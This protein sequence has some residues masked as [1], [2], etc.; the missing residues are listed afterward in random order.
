MALDQ[1]WSNA[2]EKVPNE[3]SRRLSKDEGRGPVFRLGPKQ[4]L[5]GESKWKNRS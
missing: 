2:T 4:M 3:T 1:R 5:D